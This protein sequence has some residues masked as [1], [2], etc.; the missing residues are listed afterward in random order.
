[1]PPRKQPLSPV[2][3][4]QPL[5]D[6]KPQNLPGEDLLQ[7]LVVEPWDLMEDARLIHPALGHQEM[8]MRVEIDAGPERLDDGDNTGLKCF[9][10]YGLKIEQKR[11]DG[12]SAK[13]PQELALE[14]E[15]NPKYLGDREDHLTMRDVEKKRLPDPLGPFFDPLGMAGGTEA[16]RL[17]G[18]RQQML[19]PA[20]R[21][22]DPGKAALRV[23][24]IQIALDDV[25]N[26]GPEITILLLES[27]LVF[28]DESLEMMEKQAIEDGPLRMTRAIDSRHIGKEESR[29]RPRTGVHQKI[30]GEREFWEEAGLRPLSN[31]STA[32]DH[33]IVK[34]GPHIHRD[35]YRREPREYIHGVERL[36]LCPGQ[37]LRDPY[38]C[39]QGIDAKR[40][41][42]FGLSKGGSAVRVARQMPPH[43]RSGRDSLGDGWSEDVRGR[44]R[45]R[46]LT[47]LR[48]AYLSSYFFLRM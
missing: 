19:G 24:A 14:L 5:T 20:A 17:A 6:Q 7:P 13:L 25:F 2:R 40:R 47:K 22:A 41:S 29:N 27:A 44:C 21:T 3:A 28:C 39:H 30:R 46:T 31:A 8:E 45:D 9:P 23:A 18:K 37:S 36:D 33:E 43:A 26:D 42:S 4:Q 1:V 16:P 12:T 32:V 11:S 34:T 38:R 15:E 48:P 10:R 35:G